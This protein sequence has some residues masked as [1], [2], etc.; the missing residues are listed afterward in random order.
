[1]TF[2]DV[3]P[4]RQGIEIQLEAIRNQLEA[5]ST[6]NQ[7]LYRTYLYNYAFRRAQNNNQ[8]FQKLLAYIVQRYPLPA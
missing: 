7:G 3:A 4:P 2:A 6:R 1:M 5:R 8:I